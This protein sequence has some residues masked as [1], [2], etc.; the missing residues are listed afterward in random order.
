MRSHRIRLSQHFLLS[1]KA[2]T[3][4]LVQIARMSDDEARATF[5]AVRFA[6]S[7]GRPTCPHCRSDAV[8]EFK[9]R[10][11]FKCK[12]CERQF[13]I[14]SGTI[15][16]SRKLSF[17]DILTAIALFVNG[18]S[19]VSALRLGRELNCSYKTAFV[20]LHKLREAMSSMRASRPLTGTVEIDGVWVGG[21][22]KKANVKAER[23]DRRIAHPKRLSVVTMRERRPGGRTVSVVVRQETEAFEAILQYVDPSASVRTDEGSAWAALH[24]YFDDHKTINHSVRYSEPGGIHTN[25]AESY[26]S[27]VRRAE[28]GVHHRIWGRYLLAYAEEMGW[29]ED[30]RRVDNGRQFSQV[31]VAAAK[32]PVSRAWAGYWQ[33]HLAAA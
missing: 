22:Y 18:A 7:G 14:T 23:K 12:V 6:E 32:L 26:N 31:L 20:L 17:R 9:S 13:T 8:L 29:R 2:R 28:R 25:W 5:R 19:G 3:L 16:A 10:P 27:R 24:M 30:F 33:R 11:L 1:A 4:S 21:H 15:F